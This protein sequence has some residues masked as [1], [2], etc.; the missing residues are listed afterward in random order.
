MRE[1]VL[2]HFESL[3]DIPIRFRLIV[4]L[5]FTALTIALFGV[6]PAE[7]RAEGPKIQ[8]VTV[9]QPSQI[10][11]LAAREMAV[12]LT[13]LFDAQVSIVD[14][15]RDSEEL[16]IVLASQPALKGFSNLKLELPKLDDQDH[17][18]KSAQLGNKS[19]LVVTGGSPRSTLWAAYE[20]GWRYGVRYFLFGD[21]YP[22]DA[23]AFSTQGHDVLLRPAVAKRTWHALFPSPAGPESWGLEEHQKVLGQLAKLKY[24]NAIIRASDL[25][26]GELVSGPG[27]SVSG[28]TVG[29]AAF[30]GAKVFGNPDLRPAQ[31]HADRMNAL[32]K[33]ATS[34]VTE[35]QRFGISTDVDKK[36]AERI[37]QSDSWRLLGNSVLPVTR[38][39]AFSERLRSHGAGEELVLSIGNPGDAAPEVIFLSRFAFQPTLDVAAHEA[40]LVDPVSGVGVAERVTKGLKLGELAAN[41]LIKNDPTLGSLNRDTIS[42][43]HASQEPVPAWWGEVRD[44]YL[45]AMNEMYR[46]NTRAREGGR[47]Y[48]LY[49][50]R[51]FEFG[52]E[53]MNALEAVRK[54]GLAKQAKK[55]DEQV[56]ELEKALDSITGAGNA[57][58]AVASSNSDLGAIALMNEYVYRPVQKLMEQADAE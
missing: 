56:A 20:L 2:N 43:A 13:K 17:A 42:R 30:G 55:K 36:T 38:L 23:G 27:Y 45:N 44:H 41:L 8:I 26:G 18:I 29:R 4:N 53:Y 31:S 24:T 33:L 15:A 28:D 14:G 10:E 58:A 3:P 52:Y 39:D 7:T 16:V 50:A 32:E 51:R 9:K 6:P 1:L 54:S 49:F 34:L 47:K 21:L 35:A 19:A 46:A 11:Q 22:A 37:K 25:K 48:T 5:A 57:L 40:A 12:Q